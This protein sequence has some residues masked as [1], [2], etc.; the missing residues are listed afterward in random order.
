MPQTPDPEPTAPLDDNV[1]RDDKAMSDPHAVGIDPSVPSVARV[2]DYALGGFH[3]FAADRAALDEVMADFPGYTWGVVQTRKIMGRQIRYLVEQGIDQ[4]L[5]LGSG[6]PTQANAHEAAQRL[7]PDARVVYIDHDRTAIIHAREI[8]KGNPLA[9]AAQRDLTDVEAVLSD[10][11]VADLLDLSRPVGLLMYLVLHFFPDPQAGQVVQEYMAHLAPGSY[12]GLVHAS[13]HPDLEAGFE[14][15][16]TRV[17]T[18]YLRGQ[19]QVEALLDGLEI[20]EPGV[21]YGTHWRPDPGQPVMDY[22]PGRSHGQ[23]A[24]ARKP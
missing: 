24:C 19:K 4:F 5:D 16:S 20:V 9:A 22:A 13:P 15:F 14:A 18:L 6:I 21:V 7:N 1:P 11:A 17:R 10:P 12:I 2:V 8:L 3:N 23:A